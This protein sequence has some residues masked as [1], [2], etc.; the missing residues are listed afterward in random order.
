M[1]FLL[2][3]VLVF[4]SSVA[5][6]NQQLWDR[7]RTEPNL[8]VLMRHADATSG[9][10]L[11][12]D[13]TGKCRGERVLT[14]TGRAHARKIGE[15]FAAYGIKP[16]VISSPMC[17]C[18]QTVQIAF[19]T[20]PITDPILREIASADAERVEAFETKVRSLI[21]SNRGA[22]PLV[23]ASHRPNIELLTFELISTEDLLVG[24]IYED[25]EI[26]VLGKIIPEP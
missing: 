9:D 10:P 21:T 4:L 7:L 26:D 16:V 15:Q 13:E 20:Q 11:V 17:R 8:I 25:G 6:A 22:I 24:R 1:R 14:E 5:S 23:F 18:L 3:F 12:W 2:A 19:G